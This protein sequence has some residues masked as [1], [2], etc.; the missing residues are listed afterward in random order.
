V[1][2]TKLSGI[3]PTKMIDKNKSCNNNNYSANPDKQQD[4]SKIRLT[5]PLSPTYQKLSPN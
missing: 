5:V 1:Q 2:K 3:Q 4:I